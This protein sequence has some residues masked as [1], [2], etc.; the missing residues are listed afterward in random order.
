MHVTAESIANELSKFAWYFS[1]SLHLPMLCS[2]LYLIF[3]LANIIITQTCLHDDCPLATSVTMQECVS[4]VLYR[5][6]YS[7][8]KDQ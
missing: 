3:T 6:G 1:L 5:L 2:P 8:D 4:D 7:Y